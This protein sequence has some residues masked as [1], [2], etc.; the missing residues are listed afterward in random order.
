MG[1]DGVVLETEKSGSMN[2][3]T[4]L[5]EIPRDNIIQNEVRYDIRWEKNEN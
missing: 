2:Y 4:K 3:G 1:I 5:K